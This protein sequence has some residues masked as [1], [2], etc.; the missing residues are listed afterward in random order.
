MMVIFF[1]NQLEDYDGQFLT[2]YECLLKDSQTNLLSMLSY[3]I[4]RKKLTQHNN[5]NNDPVK[6]LK[7]SDSFVGCDN[8]YYCNREEIITHS[9]Q[10]FW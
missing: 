5:F 3:C 10:T 6:L 7:F 2:R 4:G 8:Y 1:F 9:M